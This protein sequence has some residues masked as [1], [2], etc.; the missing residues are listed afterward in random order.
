MERSSGEGC[1]RGR[2]DGR[3]RPPR[4]PCGRIKGTER[5]DSARQTRTDPGH[6]HRHA[7]QNAIL[8]ETHVSTLLHMDSFFSPPKELAGL[9][10]S[11][12]LGHL[13]IGGQRPEAQDK[14]VAAPASDEASRDLSAL[15]CAPAEE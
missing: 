4:R 7:L 3:R 13:G 5:G 6:T 11:L 2:R 12:G 9:A 1:A 14:R 8:S 15:K 10:E